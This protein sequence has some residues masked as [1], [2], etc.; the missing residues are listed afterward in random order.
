ME[1]KQA[2]EKLHEMNRILV[3]AEDD[4]RK[5]TITLAHVRQVLIHWGRDYQLRNVA[6]VSGS[7]H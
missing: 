5:A 7:V 3:M 2:E 1:E 4:L 6:P